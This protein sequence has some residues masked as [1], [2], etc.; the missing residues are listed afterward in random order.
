MAQW[1]EH[2]T[3]DFGSGHGLM[4]PG[5]EPLIGLH[6]DSAEPAWDSFSPSF[7]A[8]PS[9][10]VCVCVCVCVCARARVHA[11]PFSLKINKH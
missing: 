10:P 8:P 11:L 5:F 3:L 9:S 6:A 7:S 2:S 1:V 4:V